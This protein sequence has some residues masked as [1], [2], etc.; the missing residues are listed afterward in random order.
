M[1]PYRYTAAEYWFIQFIFWSEMVPVSGMTETL[2]LNLEHKDYYI[3]CGN[4]N[5]NFKVMKYSMYTH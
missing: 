1:V 4:L 5:L 3:I 2:N